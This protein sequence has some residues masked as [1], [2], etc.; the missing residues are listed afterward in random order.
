MRLGVNVVGFDD[1]VGDPK[2]HGGLGPEADAAAASA[3]GRP[4]T[5]A[6]TSASA[7]H[8]T[9]SVAVAAKTAKTGAVAIELHVSVGNGIVAEGT[10]SYLARRTL[11]FSRPSE[12]RLTGISLGQ[13]PLSWA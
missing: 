2:G 13:A 9:V 8:V 6:N 12:R 11:L 5:S 1:P 10:G 4:G 3:A 7:C